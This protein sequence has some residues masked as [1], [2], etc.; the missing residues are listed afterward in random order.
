MLGWK[1]NSS[2]EPLMEG[3]SLPHNSFRGS[4]GSLLPRRIHSVYQAAT[5]PR[6]VAKRFSWHPW[7]SAVVNW[8][9]APNATSSLKQ[10]YT[11]MLFAMWLVG[12]V[13]YLAA[14]ALSHVTCLGQWSM[15][16]SLSV[17]VPSFK[18]HHVSNLL[19]SCHHHNKGPAIPHMRHTA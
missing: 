3:E 9:M 5:L 16:G 8:I 2:L 12:G 13:Y 11:P 17:T 4:C 19:H 10:N 1:D 7:L 18:R 6:L 14:L 15:G